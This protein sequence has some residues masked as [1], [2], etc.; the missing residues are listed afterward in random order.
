M[1]NLSACQDVMSTEADLSYMRPFGRD[2]LGTKRVLDPPPL[3]SGPRL[4]LRIE[5]AHSQEGAGAHPIHFGK[6][7]E[8]AVAQ[9]DKIKGWGPLGWRQ[10][11][12][13]KQ[14]ASMESASRLVWPDEPRISTAQRF[15]GVKIISSD[16]REGFE[17]HWCML[18]VSVAP[19]ERTYERSMLVVDDAQI[20]ASYAGRFNMQTSNVFREESAYDADAVPRVRVCVPVVCSVLGSI[21]PEVATQGEYVTL[22]PYPSP[23]V[24]KFVFD[25]S[26]DFLELPQ[27]FFHYVTWASGG[28]ELVADIQGFQDDDGIT[29]VDPVVLKAD[30]PTV[31]SLLK[32]VVG[33]KEEGEAGQAVNEERFNLCHPHC[34]QLCRHFDPHRRGVHIRRHC[35][36]SAPS[37]DARG[38]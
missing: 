35:G 24:R 22:L 33:V 2:V 17:E 36:F 26:E 23:E 32:V 30:K 15:W 25:G 31:G 27:A 34:G 9:L 29:I 5:L 1:G 11:S 10:E 12:S 38:L 19:Q 3:P 14:R 20:A 6:G 16:G 37:C 8:V 21:V 18:Q 7:D 28:H 4:A 13:A